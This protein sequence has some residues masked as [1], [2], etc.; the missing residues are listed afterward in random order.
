MHYARWLLV[1]RVLI[2]LDYVQFSYFHSGQW[3][4]IGTVFEALWYL[5][6]SKLGSLFGVKVIKVGRIAILIFSKFWG[7]LFGGIIL[8]GPP[9]N[10][11]Q[12]ERGF[13]I[14]GGPFLVVL[15]CTFFGQSLGGQGKSP[16]VL[17]KPQ[18]G[19]I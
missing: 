11:G 15:S 10:N 16:R 13:N 7:P 8:W 3:W 4:F 14:T 2:F 17:K 1:P 18:Q 19:G 9:F 6:S 12:R 5:F